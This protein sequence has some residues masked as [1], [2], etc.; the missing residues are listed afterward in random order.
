ML[1]TA[2]VRPG[3]GQMLK[4]INNLLSFVA[5]EATAEAMALGVPAGLDPAIMPKTFNSGTGRNS[6]TERKF[7]HPVVTPGFVVG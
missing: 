1:V 5:L 2:G 7:P 4:V 3:D 6:P